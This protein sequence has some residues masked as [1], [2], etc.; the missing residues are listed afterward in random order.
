MDINIQSIP[1]LA[2]QKTSIYNKVL[3]QLNLGN[4]ES[5]DEFM[6]F[7]KRFIMH[8]EQI[9]GS[10]PSNL[11]LLVLLLEEHEEIRRL[12]YKVECLE[13]RLLVE[14]SGAPPRFIPP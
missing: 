11:Y 5:L 14:I 8:P 7:M 2:K 13:E 3:I 6:T 10:L 9:D 4:Q 12:K 1:D